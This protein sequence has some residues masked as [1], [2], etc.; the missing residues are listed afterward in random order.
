[1]KVTAVAGVAGSLAGERDREACAYIARGR[2]SFGRFYGDR[3][4]DDPAAVD[5][6]GRGN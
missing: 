5:P 6:S 2:W 1:M 3:R 4:G